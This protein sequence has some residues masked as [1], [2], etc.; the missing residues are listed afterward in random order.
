MTMKDLIKKRINEEDGTLTVFMTLILV[1]MMAFLLGY[2]T[3]SK[4]SAV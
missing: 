2:E 4:Y 3:R 1:S